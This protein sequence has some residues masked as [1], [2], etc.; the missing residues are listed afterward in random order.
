[1]ASRDGDS[2]PWSNETLPCSVAPESF[3]KGLLFRPANANSVFALDMAE[4][5]SSPMRAG[6]GGLDEAT[7][8]V[9]FHKGGHS[10]LQ[11]PPH[12]EQAVVGKSLL[13]IHLDAFSLRAVNVC[14]Y[15]SHLGHF[16]HLGSLERNWASPL[17]HPAHRDVRR[18]EI[19]KITISLKPQLPSF[20]LSLWLVAYQLME[21]PGLRLP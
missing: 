4:H 9:P 8:S 12:A 10:P 13:L 18:G 15:F 16:G 3:L 20:A 1:M 2:G 17:S 19:C 5:R 14:S 6:G 21:L 7:F 11:L